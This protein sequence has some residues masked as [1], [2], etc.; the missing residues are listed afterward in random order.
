MR[1]IDEIALSHN[2][3]GEIVTDETHALMNQETF[4]QLVNYSGSFPT[5]TTLGKLW[6]RRSKDGWRLCEY[7]KS[8]E[9]GWVDVKMYTIIVI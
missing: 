8:S 2:P 4:D 1:T 6:K 3:T 9:P 7:V 5:G